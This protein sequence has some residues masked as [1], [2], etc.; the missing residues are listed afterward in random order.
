M[1]KIRPILLKALETILPKDLP[2]HVIDFGIGRGDETSFLLQKGYSVTAID[3]FEEFLTE[4]KLR[5][6]TQP[7][8]D[9]LS[10]IKA[11]FEELD[12]NVLPTA[13]L[14][15]AS[16]SLGYIQPDQFLTVWKNIVS[17]IQP[18]GYFVGHLYTHLHV[19]KQTDGYFVTE[20][21]PPIAFLTKEAIIK[22]FTDFTIVYF[23]DAKALYGEPIDPSTNA[24]IYSVI[25]QKN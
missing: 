5:E 12:W 13:D 23:E 9:K 19:N 16:F 11:N 24:K 20:D 21:S 14:F 25:A 3:N 18:G 4:I 15:L 6:D 8:L 10:T 17:H 1:Y 22:L 2:G 7:F